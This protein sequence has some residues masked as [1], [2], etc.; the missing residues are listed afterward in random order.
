[1]KLDEAYNKVGE[2][3]V[4]KK[5]HE[6]NNDSYLC[7]AFVMYDPKV[8]NEWQLGYYNKESD[9]I[10]TFTVSDKITKNPES[11]VFKEKGIVKKLDFEKVKI[12]VEEADKISS[13]VQ[14]KE[15]SAHLP[16]KKIMILQNLDVGQVWNITLVT[17]TFK[18]INIKVDSFSGKVIKHTLVDFFKVEK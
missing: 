6:E 8:K 5:W 17:A 11:E 4:F 12:T 13:D 2:S 7:H 15:Y 10:V 18:T 16:V 1:M 9:R 3:Q 14:K